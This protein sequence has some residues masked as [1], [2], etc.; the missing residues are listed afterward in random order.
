MPTI[1]AHIISPSALPA[2]YKFVCDSEMNPI[3]EKPFTVIVPEGG[4]REGEVFL[5]PLPQSM[6]DESGT[7]PPTGFWKDGLFSCL[8]FGV[9]HPHLCCAMLC[10]PIGMAQIMQR[11]RLTWLG[12]PGPRTSTQYT[13][14]IVLVMVCSYLVYSQ[15]LYLYGETGGSVYF[16]RIF[17]SIMFTFWSIYALYK[18]RRTVRQKYSIPEERCEGFEDLYCSIFCSCCTVAQI[19]RHTGDYDTNQAMCC[20]STGLLPTT[21][22]IL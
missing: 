3:P 9:F 14:N 5:Y 22:S 21:S 8:N 17:G 15:S 12:L 4:V 1:M 7:Q 13:F 10:T 18:T 11:L 6:I 2:G 16:F 19:A 20:T